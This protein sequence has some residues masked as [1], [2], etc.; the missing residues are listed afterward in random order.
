MA[1]PTTRRPSKGRANSNTYAGAPED[2]PH[3]SG[4]QSLGTPDNTDTDEGAPKKGKKKTDDDSDTHETAIKRWTAGHE[5]DRENIDLA[6]EDLE[7]LE[8][9]Q[10]P[11]DAVTARESEK[12]PVQTFNR[13]PQFVRQITGDMRLAKP[14]IKVVPVDSGSD[15]EIARIRA[16]L[17][18]YVENRSDAQHAYYHGADQQVAAGIGHWRVIKEYADDTTFNQEL[19]VVSVD[20]GISVIWDPDAILPNKEDA[21]YCFVPVDM[22]RERYKERWPDN[23]ISDFAD[24]TKAIAGGWMGSDF[25]RVCEYWCKEPSTRI[26]ALLPSGGIDDITDDDAKA[27]A[28]KAKGIR[29]EKRESYKVC[30][31]LI[32]FGGILEGPVDWPG[33]FIPIVRCPGEETRI[34]RKTKRRGI[35]RFAKDAQ[36]AYNYGRSTQ[37]EITSLQPKAPFIGTEKNFQQYDDYWSQANVKAFPYLPYTPDPLNGN[38]PPQRV[39]PPLSSQGVNENVALAADDMKAVIGIYDA[40]L[41]QRSNETSGKAIQAR[42]RQSDVGS[43][44]YQDNWSRAIR[45]TATILNDLIPH[46]YDAERSIRI[47]GEDGKEELIELNKAV[48]GDGMEE[49]EQVLNDITIGAYD[50]VFQPG[51]SFSTR[52]EEAREGMTNFM[53][54][55]PQAAPLILD[56]VADAQDWPNADKIGKR[57]ESMLPPEVKAREAQERGEPPPPPLPPSPQQQAAQQADQMK[58][59]HEQMQMQGSL[60]KIQLENEGKQLDNQRRQIEL[61]AAVHGARPAAPTQPGPPQ[62]D[63]MAMAVEHERAQADIIEAQA[64]AAIAQA[65]VRKAMIDLAIKEREFAA[66]MQG[67]DAKVS[68][69]INY[70]DLPPEGQVQMAAEAGIMIDTPAPQPDN[71]TTAADAAIMPQLEG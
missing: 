70:K 42:D 37:T 39:S 3:S 23:P 31:Y 33:R 12:R 25:V 58:L 63:P 29:V 14:A 48:P 64:R 15:K 40:A 71:A 18:R 10:W 49:T 9:D 2:A 41:G 17:I 4:M 65:N 19:R 34:G 57:L 56:L 62:A 52:R 5:R 16:G 55:A 44:V 66:T 50:V 60:Q 28:H 7:F 46:V 53:Q 32:S 27:A 69:S 26:L 43:F 38:I 59:Q 67:G 20:D 21:Q 6:Y 61:Q 8:G 54:A 24:D 11:A 45:H 30:R 68:Q 47:L 1:K 51:P 36:R 35:I 22:S 13:M